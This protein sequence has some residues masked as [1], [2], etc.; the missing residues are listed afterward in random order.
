MG[1]IFREGDSK[2]LGRKIRFLISSMND[3]VSVRA[4][5]HFV[6]IY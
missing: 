2:P 5:R 1:G 3:G 4:E 6:L